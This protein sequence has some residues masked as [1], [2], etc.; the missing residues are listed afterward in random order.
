MKYNF[1]SWQ[2]KKK[3][4]TTGDKMAASFISPP[5]SLS[6]EHDGWMGKWMLC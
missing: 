4:K 6:L 2:V 5:L 3:Q 1:V